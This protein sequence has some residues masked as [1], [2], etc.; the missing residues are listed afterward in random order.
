MKNQVKASAFIQWYIDENT[1]E[2]I[3]KR[4]VEDLITGGISCINVRQLFDE[5]GY[6]PME[7]C[8]YKVTDQQNEVEYD[9]SEVNFIDDITKPVNKT[10]EAIEHLKGLGYNTE[11]LWH[12]WDVTERFNCTEQQ[13][14]EVLNKALAN[15]WLTEQTHFIIG[16]TAEAMGL[17]EKEENE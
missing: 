3:T 9:P 13:A 6:I 11:S 14:H 8:D 7:I 15:Q 2:T 17:G 10:Q 16:K 4:M 5:C 12:V 1:T